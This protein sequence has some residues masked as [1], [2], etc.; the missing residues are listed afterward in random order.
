M[1]STPERSGWATGE[2]RSMPGPAYMG[3]GSENPKEGSGAL[4][5]EVLEGKVET[6]V[7]A[8]RSFQKPVAI[9]LHTATSVRSMQAVA[10]VQQRYS[11]SGLPFYNSI[12]AAARAIGKF[13]DHH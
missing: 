2:T 9:A 4:G 1:Y 11:S 5:V 13:L 8:A 7:R 10:E 3:V 6:I 12:G